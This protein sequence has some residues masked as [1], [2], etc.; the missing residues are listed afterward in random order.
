[1]VVGLVR[2]WRVLASS[3]SGNALHFDSPKCAFRFQ[4]NT[5]LFDLRFTEYYSQKLV[6]VEELDFVRGSDVIGP[7]GHDLVPVAGRSNAE[8]FAREHGGVR[9]DAADIDRTLLDLLDSPT[10][11]RMPP[12]AA[13]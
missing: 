13:R 4:Q 6:S 3:G 10:A 9:L 8:R 7:M 1:M 12:S 11:P 5:P 2:S